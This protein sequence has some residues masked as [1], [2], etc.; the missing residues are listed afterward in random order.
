M[1]QQI[2]KESTSAILYVSHSKEE[3]LVPQQ[4]LELHPG[5][6]GSVATIF[7]N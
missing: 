3:G 7:K 5:I 4:V 1:I 2:A 6:A